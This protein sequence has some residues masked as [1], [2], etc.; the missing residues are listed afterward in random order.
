MHG[1]IARARQVNV[2]VSAPWPRYEA[3]FAAEISEFLA[4]ESPELFWK[5]T[6]LLCESPRADVA[7]GGEGEAAGQA[8]LSAGFNAAQSLLPRS[9]HTL[10]DTVLGLSVYS[11]TVQFFHTLADGFARHA[12]NASEGSAVSGDAGSSL[13][14]LCG[15]RAWAVVY[16]GGQVAC[17]AAALSALLAEPDEHGRG[18]QDVTFG[19]TADEDAAWDHR[20]ARAEHAKTH[21]VVYGSLGTE[22]FCRLHTRALAEVTAPASAAATGPESTS[23]DESDS[24]AGDFADTTAYSVR[25]AFPG[26]RPL[27]AATRL[28]GFGVFLDIKNMEYKSVNDDA[29]GKEGAGASSEADLTPDHFPEGEE[30]AGVVLSTLLKNHPDTDLHDLSVLWE[31]LQEQEKANRRILSGAADEAEE[32]DISHMKLWRMKDLGVQTVHSILSSNVR[33]V[34]ICAVNCVLLLVLVDGQR[35]RVASAI[36]KPYCQY[37]LPH[38][39]ITC[40]AR[41]PTW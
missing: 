20:W 3:S 13:H 34:T 27:A 29:A 26:M 10:L 7:A 31:E 18:V 22:S 11:P 32:E 21:V 4:H 2:D 41:E 38:A 19:H 12:V 14:A 39:N 30:A 23:A 36:I 16:P 25:H 37:V 5:Y 28:Q 9:L 33:S 35:I 15:S 1:R 6:N 40:G 8:A 24:H 17:D